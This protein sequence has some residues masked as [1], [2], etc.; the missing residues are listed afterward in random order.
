MVTLPQVAQLTVGNLSKVKK[1]EQELGVVLIAYKP[2]EFANLTE[3][4]VKELQKVEKDLKATVIAY[5]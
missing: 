5:Q 4:Q 1:L 2:T 3:A